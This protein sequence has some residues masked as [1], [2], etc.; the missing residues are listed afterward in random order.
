MKTDF[1][2]LKILCDANGFEL[3][4][5]SPKDNDKFY[6]VKK[7]DEWEVVEFVEGLVVGGVYKI[8]DFDNFQRVKKFY[9]PSTEQ[10]Y[11]D[12]LKK[13]AFELYGEIKEG[14]RFDAI[15]YGN[16]VTIGKGL[17]FYYCK[18]TDALHFNG[19]IVYEKGIWAKKLPKRVEVKPK[20]SRGMNKS[21]DVLTWDYEFEFKINQFDRE[22]FSAEIMHWKVLPFL[23]SQLEKYLNGEVE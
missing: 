5:E 12:Q 22:K 19:W 18:S 8:N 6:V 20:H 4:T 1:E 16:T 15:F 21:H 9:K 13:Q 10:A 7:K 3:L 2:K 17:G 23:A 14:D 11:V